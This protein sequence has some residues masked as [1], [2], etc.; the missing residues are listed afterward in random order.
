M[1]RNFRITLLSSVASFALTV[2]SVPVQAQTTASASATNDQSKIEE[3]VVTG[4]PGGAGVLKQDASFAITTLDAADIA[5]V[6]P[7][8][9]AD[10]FKTIPGVW[11]ESTGGESGAN[12]F[13]RGFPTGGDADFLTVQ[14]NGSPIF[15]PPTLSFLENSSLFRI[16]ETVDRVEGL[17][18]GPSSVFSNGQPGLTVNFIDKQGGPDYSGLLK[19]SGTDFD[20]RRVDAVL[21]GPI[22]ND[23]Y[24]MV[25]G[26]YRASNGIRDAQFTAEDGGQI[27]ANI[28]HKFDRGELMV[29]GR[30][31][32]DRNQ[33]LLPIPLI[34]NANGSLSE[35]PGFDAGTGTYVGN[36]TRVGILEV[37]PGTRTI[38]RKLDEGRG[39]E[40]G[41]IG[42][43]FDYKLGYG[44]TFRNH[45][46]YT[47]GE[48]N[49]FGLV[50]VAPPVSAQ[51]FL[52]TF[53]AAGG[54]YTFA[55]SGATLTDLT[56]PVMQVGWWSVQ[57]DIQSVS[58]EASIA[59]QLFTGNTATAGFYYA[60]ITTD[61]LWYL[62]NNQLVVAE[63]NSRKLN[64]VLNDGRIVT[65]D[66]FSGSPFF[67]L[68]AS[69][70]G[71]SFAGYF[72]DDW[73]ITD[74]LRVDGGVRIENF[75]AA[76]RIENV[77]SEDLDNNPNTLYDNNASVLNGTF[78]RV[79]FNDT[80]VSW[81]V[82]A[83]Y[84]F[85]DQ[86]GTFVRL[87]HGHKFP[88]FDNLRDG[89]KN[90]QDVKQYET[91][92][93]V[94]TDRVGLY[95]TFFYAEFDGLP[96]QRF[97][98]GQNIVDAGGARSYGFEVEANAQIY[99]GLSAN[100]SGTW[101]H[102]E[103]DNFFTGA[104]DQSGN[105][106][107]RQPRW[108]IRFT[109]NYTRPFSWGF[110]TLYGTL[111]YV[112]DRFSDVENTQLLPSYTKFDAGL[113]IGYGNNWTFQV[114]GDN[115]T[116][117]LAITEGNPRII[118]SQGTGPIL[119]RPLLGRSFQFSLKY[120]F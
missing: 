40:V 43:K 94:T 114:T 105:R 3:V 77:S 75:G 87:S 95:S 41:M 85:N 92:L 120:A 10:L 32:K 20:E 52:N 49:T 51:A 27:N 118:G 48:A 5:Q 36:D 66:G 45:I 79:A 60:Y 47:R 54:T 57:K 23:T 83:N 50:P 69:Y 62:G 31:L 16:D 78:R 63:P 71:R 106:V 103:Y 42:S 7:T 107:Q 46:L 24:F 91:G 90:I 74:A 82:G 17:R 112:G 86:V 28:V 93:K 44:L 119:G 99:E 109:P 56:T 12:V 113:I 2:L 68:N 80:E 100:V 58:E 13:V 115:L 117:K 81:T 108:Q 14:L 8:S 72:S 65:R 53:G 67:S 26:F 18:G 25:G 4:T 35:F 11:S 70:Y 76:G 6:A 102:G 96:F 111:T 21:S 59:K 61:D 1:T 34:Q 98:N 116:D 104:G 97:I 39:P 15:P 22:A 19:V 55:T 101:L 30:F 38:R 89:A 88:Q 110:G 64:L 37:G 84:A 73:Q 29:Y 33:W 9:T